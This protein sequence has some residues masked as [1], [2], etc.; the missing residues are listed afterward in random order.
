MDKAALKGQRPYLLKCLEVEL[1]EG[2]LALTDP[3][4]PIFDIRG[5]PIK[6]C[7]AILIEEFNRRFPVTRWQKDFFPLRQG[8][9]QFKVDIDKLLIMAIEADLAYGIAEDLT[10]IMRIVGCKDDE[11]QGDLQKLESQQMC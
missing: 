9:Q 4:T 2:M 7:M 3:R 5:N 10:D 8:G 6:S 1:G 11:L